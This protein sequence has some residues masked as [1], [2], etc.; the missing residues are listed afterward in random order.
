MTHL[1]RW[2]K[3]LMDGLDAQ[4]DEETRA[5]I[6]EACGRGCIPRSF[7]R[8]AQACRR[9]ARDTGEFLD[10]LSQRWSHLQRDGDD[11]YVT[12][13]KCYCPLVK[14]YS[15]ELSPSFCNC[16]RGWI[17]ELFESVLERPVSVDLEKSIKRGDDLC[18]L[19]VRL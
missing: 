15:G 6:L 7:I 5:E 11:I 3:T 13:E 16:S 8:K 18:R 1:Q 12:Y 4:V 2:V 19:R 10:R 17:K 14:A 9:G